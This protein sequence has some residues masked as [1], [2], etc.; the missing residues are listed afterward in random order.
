MMT[1]KQERV[2][3]ANALIRAIS[4]HGRRFFYSYEHD[5]VARMSIDPRGKVW[6][7]DE[8]TNVRIYTHYQYRWRGF[9][10]GGTLRD[11]VIAMRDYIRTG[12]KIPRHQIATER[13]W[14]GG[15]VWGYGP[16]AASAVRDECFVLPIM[17]D[18]A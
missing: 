15:N 10:H 5:R 14:S 11:L 1:T 8:R 13:G 16:D 2:E 12:Q 3:H 4:S 6:F 18:V 7:I 17:E 9:S